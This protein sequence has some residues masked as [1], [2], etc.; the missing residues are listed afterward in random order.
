MTKPPKTRPIGGAGRAPGRAPGGSSLLNV[1]AQRQDLIIPTAVVG[2]LMLMILPLP[3]LALDLLLALSI[4]MSLVV[5]LTA[6]HIVRPLEFSVFPSVLLVLTLFRLALNVASTRLILLNGAEGD[7]AG[8]VI[9]T[10]GSFVVGGNTVV[11]VVIFLIL[12]LINFAVIT[13]GSGRIAEVAARFT[14]DA[15]PGKQMSIDAD[16]NAGLI[17]QAEA[18]A[19]RVEV[20]READFYGAMD[21]SSKFVR[22]DAVAGLIITA[23][24]IIGG[25]VVGVAQKGMSFGEAAQ[26]YS[27]LTVGDGLVSQLPALLISTA[28]GV[29]VSRAAGA[30]RLGDE[31]S[32]Q[33]LRQPVVLWLAAVI[34][35]ALALVPGMPLLAF[36]PLAVAL[37]YFARRALAGGADASSGEEGSAEDGAAPKDEP[38]AE[39]LA[40]ERLQLEVGYQL[41]S[42][43]DGARGGSLPER[44]VGIRKLIARELGVVVP[45]IHV[46]DNLDLAPGD[47]RLLLSGAPIGNGSIRAG[48]LLAMGPDG[49]AEKVE[50]EPTREPAFGLDAL[51]IDPALERR[52]QT[53][54]YTV[55][56]P[57]SVIATHLTEL[58]RAN[59]AELLGRQELQ[60]LLDVVS[61]RTPRV[62]EE[63]I[64]KLLST[65]EVIQVL[66]RLLEESVSIRDLRTILEAL[67]DHAATS[68]NVFALTELVRRRLAN[69]IS[70]SLADADGVIHAALPDRA[71]EDVL[72]GGVVEAEGRPQLALDLSAAE[73]LMS[74]VRS[75]IDRLAVQDRPAV[76]AVPSDVRAPL[77]DLLR[78][79]F[80]ELHVVAHHELSPRVTLRA[81]ATVAG[82]DAV[83]AR[84]AGHGARLDARAA[85]VTG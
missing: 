33:L 27:V 80:P 66:R 55:V 9:S 56:D 45:P 4:S 15:L 52:A 43:V 73:L 13:K 17:D 12:V 84:A 24:N 78:R 37:G 75:A 28:A 82:G 48:R 10:F 7:G 79:F 54:G 16:L 58:L 59:A 30:S 74:Q 71:M 83:A 31:V 49:V 53:A 34:V 38:L 26:T 57:T 44:I 65:G 39:L 19:R 23:I 62:V 18:G 21:G 47:Y 63:L 68:R 11:G 64:P 60:E 61:E 40:V 14:L 29:I 76:L 6:A 8:A 67:A 69:Q 42:L 85:R 46:R 3:P 2:I 32:G 41:V 81:A 50:G 36:A 77:R 70:A 25:L 35:G 51:W 5:L 22:G 1:V 20:G 72:R